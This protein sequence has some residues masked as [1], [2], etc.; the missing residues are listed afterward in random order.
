MRRQWL[1][2]VLGTAIAFLVL[3]TVTFMLIYLEFTLDVTKAHKPGG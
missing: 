2:G 3:A 1:R